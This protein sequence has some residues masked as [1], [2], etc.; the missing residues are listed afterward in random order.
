VTHGQRHY[1]WDFVTPVALNSRGEQIYHRFESDQDLSRMW[2]WK[3]E[4]AVDQHMAVRERGLAELARTEEISR[5][6]K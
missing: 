6:G 4:R 3:M 5:D 1:P 2:E